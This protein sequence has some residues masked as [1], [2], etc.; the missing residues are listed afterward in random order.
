VN[1]TE[2]VGFAQLAFLGNEIA[3]N[4]A[5]NDHPTYG[6]LLMVLTEDGTWDGRKLS[7]LFLFSSI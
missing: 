2:R 1:L 4:A 5:T 3:N 6:K 7:G